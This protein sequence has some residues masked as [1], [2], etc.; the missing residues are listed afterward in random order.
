MI[1][2]TIIL[3][4]VN[5][6]YGSKEKNRRKLEISEFDAMKKKISKRVFNFLEINKN[7]S[8]CSTILIS[9][10]FIHLWWSY[11]QLSNNLAALFKIR[12]HVHVLTPFHYA[13][14]LFCFFK[15]CQWLWNTGQLQYWQL[16]LKLVPSN[17]E[18]SCVELIFMNKFFNAATL[19]KM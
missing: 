18:L 3:D 13:V 1:P 19:V 16:Q 8:F 7:R 14:W 12:A 4:Q 2:N 5:I 17:N 10:I 11:K 6:S 15:H 9:Y